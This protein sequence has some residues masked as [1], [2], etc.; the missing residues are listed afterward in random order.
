MP[1]SIHNSKPSVAD[2]RGRKSGGF[3]EWRGRVVIRRRIKQ[4]FQ[5]C[6]ASSF[7]SFLKLFMYLLG[8]T[9]LVVACIL[10]SCGVWNLVP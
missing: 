10:F 5:G 7:F 4:D 1:L 6:W 8:C 9:E 2:L 3:G